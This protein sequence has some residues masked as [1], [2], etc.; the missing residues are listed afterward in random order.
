[1]TAEYA[2]THG[3][4]LIIIMTDQDENITGRLMGPYAQQIVNHS[5]IPV[6][7]IQPVLGEGSWAD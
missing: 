5:K 1:M 7:S 3:T 2:Q 6:M 4:D